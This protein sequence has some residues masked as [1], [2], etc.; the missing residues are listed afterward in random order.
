MKSDD[1]VNNSTDIGELQDTLGV[2]I[3]SYTYLFDPWARVEEVN[4]MIT[5]ELAILKGLG[6]LNTISDVR[7]NGKF[8]TY[9]LLFK[10][11]RNRWQRAVEKY[12]PD[13]GGWK[14]ALKDVAELRDG[15]MEI[16]VK[17]GLISLS[18]DMFT[19]Q[20]PQMPGAQGQNG[21]SP[22]PK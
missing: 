2:I 5:F 18:S 11:F 17:E 9:R 4:H 1:E 21:T 6:K 19:L 3:A 12:N 7:V 20:I 10:F 8:V 13:I 22:Q 16:A 15:L 14:D